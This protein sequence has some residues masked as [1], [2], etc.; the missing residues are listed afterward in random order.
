MEFT[1]D[2]KLEKI[3]LSIITEVVPEKYERTKITKET[4]LWR[5]LGLTSIGILSLAFR[6]QEVLGIDLDTLNIEINLSQLLTVND[7]INLGKE[8]LAKARAVA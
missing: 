2:D 7:A 5:E 3:I 6:L 1:Q 8:L 4:H